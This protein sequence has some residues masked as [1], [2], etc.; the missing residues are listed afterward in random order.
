MEFR[1]IEW[2]ADLADDCRQV[3][4]LAVREDLDR[5]QDWTT[6]AL[7]PQ[8]ARGESEI[9]ARH[10]GVLA[11]LKAIPLVLEE[12][13]TQLQWEPVH[14]EGSRVR[15]G[16]TVGHLRGSLRDM[17]VAE[18]PLLNLIGRLS[19]IA[20]LT[21]QYVRQIAGLAA[22]IYDTRKTTPGWRRLE[23]YAVRCGGGR[24]HRTGLFDAILIKDNHLALAGL[25][26]EPAAAI[27]QVR[28]YLGELASHYPDLQQL[29][30]E[31]EVDDLDQFRSALE[32]RPDIILLDNMTPTQLREAVEYRD[33]I[34]PATQ[35]E[36]SGGVNLETVRGIAESGVERISVGAIT[37]SAVN[38][39]VALDIRHPSGNS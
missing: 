4:R 14:T 32:A 5:W 37:H 26:R 7:I 23:K 21:D 25:A 22:G 16:E 8:G 30:I 18:R 24:N 17:L 19:G 2:D 11:G 9:V 35:L 6:L 28:E 33:R 10:S 36:A 13:Q 20:T 39:D 15:S 31:I 1:Q 38:F 34:Q 12:M 29:P 3:I 27:R